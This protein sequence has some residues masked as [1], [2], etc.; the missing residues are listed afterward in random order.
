MCSSDLAASAVGAAAAWGIDRAIDPSTSPA[1][2]A[3]VVVAGA[4]GLG[5]AIGGAALAG[6]PEIAELRTT[7]TRTPRAGGMTSA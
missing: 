5:I 6:V 1:A 3:T 4:V 2:I 7:L